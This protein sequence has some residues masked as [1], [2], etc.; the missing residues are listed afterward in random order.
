VVLGGYLED[1]VNPGD[2]EVLDI[3]DPENTRR[4]VKPAP[5]PRGFQRG[6]AAFVEF[7]IVVCGGDSEDEVAVEVGR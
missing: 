2:V 7:T 1:G 3:S 6:V 4:C 5:L